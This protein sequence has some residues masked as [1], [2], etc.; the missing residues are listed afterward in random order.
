MVSRVEMLLFLALHD[1][2][3]T[4]LEGEAAALVAEEEEEE[5]MKGTEATFTGA[6]GVTAVVLAGSEVLTAAWLEEE[7]KI[8]LD[9]KLSDDSDPSQK[10]RRRFT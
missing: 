6:V 10:L 9:A 8:E 3:R 7:A 2:L 5:E 1:V 4:E